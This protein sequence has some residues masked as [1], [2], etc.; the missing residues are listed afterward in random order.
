MEEMGGDSETEN[1][2]AEPSPAT[3]QGA[4]CWVLALEDSPGCLSWPCPQHSL[5]PSH[6]RGTATEE[7]QCRSVEGTRTGTWSRT[8][9]VLA[10]EWP[11]NGK[12]QGQ[13]R[14]HGPPKGKGAC[15]TGQGS[16]ELALGLKG[17]M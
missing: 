3:S 13:Q 6:S 1:W 12:V 8:G 5:S 14:T 4:L 17:R 15:S 10:L 11:L 16:T 9:L 7:A 2:P